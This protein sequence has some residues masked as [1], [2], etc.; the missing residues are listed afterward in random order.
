MSRYVCKFNYQIAARAMKRQGVDNWQ[1]IV[2]LDI[3][4]TCILH[5]HVLIVSE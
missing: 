2:K 3:Q 1:Y 4:C 5:V